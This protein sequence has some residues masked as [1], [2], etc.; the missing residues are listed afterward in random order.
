M[1]T[2]RLLSP[3]SLWI[4]FVA[5]CASSNA[6]APAVP[7]TPAATG[8]P[9]AVAAPS[10]GAVPPPSN[11]DAEAAAKVPQGHEDQR[12][13]ALNAEA[14]ALYWQGREFGDNAAALMAIARYR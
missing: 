14:G 12:W 1:T 4:A 5:G 11:V 13:K 6:A 2:P 10:V 8:A 3:L 9:A 7:A